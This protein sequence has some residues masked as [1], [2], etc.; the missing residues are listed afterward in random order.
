MGQIAIILYSNPRFPEKSVIPNNKKIVLESEN[1]DA[2]EVI[3]HKLQFETETAHLFNTGA[4]I[5]V[6]PITKTIIN[7]IY[8]DYHVRYPKLMQLVKYLEKFEDGEMFYYFDG[9]QTSV[10]ERLT[11]IQCLPFFP[12]IGFVKTVHNKFFHH[13]FMM[14]SM[15]EHYSFGFDGLECKAGEEDKEKRCCRF[16]NTTGKGNFRKIA[17]AIP[18]ALGNKLLFCNEECDSCNSRLASVESHFVHLMDIRRALC[19]VPTKKTSKVISLYG[20]NFTLLPDEQGSPNLYVKREEVKHMGNGRYSYHLKNSSEVTNEGI[21]KALVKMVIDLMPTSELTHFRNTITWINGCQTDRNLPSVFYAVR[22]PKEHLYLQPRLDL[23]LNTQQKYIDSPYCTAIL[24]TTDIQY[25][26]VVPFVDIDMGQFKYN[27]QL[28][29]HWKRMFTML[30]PRQWVEQNT[31]DTNPAYTW[32]NFEFS[33]SNKNVHILDGF[34]G[35]FKKYKTEEEKWL[36]NNHQFPIFEQKLITV[37]SVSNV[38]FENLCNRWVSQKELSDVSINHN[39][40]ESFVVM[41]TSNNSVLVHLEFEVFNSD[42][43]TPFFG[44]KGTVKLEAKSMDKFIL[45]TEN[46]DTTNIEMDWTFHKSV[47]LKSAKAIEDKMRKQ[48]VG[49]PFVN[50]SFEMAFDS[51][52]IIRA[53]HVRYV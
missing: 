5:K 25:I 27:D 51:E 28:L 13:Y 17:H 19:K 15:F 53:I 29:G 26:F 10:Q 24:F 52:R 35:I 3:K 46:N 11:A 43:T 34:E 45:V 31:S 30:T 14:G 22:S 42:N 37:E 36:L 44:C 49:S 32:L 4:L 18:E 23:F 40:G 20:E 8:A 38:C 21:Y 12:T 33:R 7:A 9:E 50:C 47:V 39:L 48:R 16:C 1:G 41:D 2:L 6:S